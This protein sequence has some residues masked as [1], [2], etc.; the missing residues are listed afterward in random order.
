MFTCAAA[1][2]ADILVLGAFGCGAFRNDPTVVANAYKT[3]M[4]VFP[5]VFDKIEFAVY[6]P[7]GRSENYDV[8]SRVLGR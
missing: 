7:P 6:C 2:K 5:K 1:N 3:A 4:S 8:F